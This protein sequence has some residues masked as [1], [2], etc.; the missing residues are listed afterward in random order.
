[1][2]HLDGHGVFASCVSASV[3]ADVLYVC[4]YVQVASLTGNGDVAAAVAALNAEMDRTGALHLH[5]ILSALG[6]MALSTT[7]AVEA[8]ELAAVALG[9]CAADT[10]LLPCLSPA[11]RL[12]FKMVGLG[13]LEDGAGKALEAVLGV[14]PALPSE[15]AADA[16]HLLVTLLSLD[17]SVLNIYLVTIASYPASLP[18]VEVL[19]QL[20]TLGCVSPEWLGLWCVKAAPG[21]G[22]ALAAALDHPRFIPVFVSLLEV[23]S[24][25]PAACE[26]VCSVMAACARAASCAT[27]PH[28]LTDTLLALVYSAA[29]QVGGEW[30]GV[31]VRVCVPVRCVNDLSTVSVIVCE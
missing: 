24:V 7:L 30:S 13:V 10:S 3:L 11:V 29:F 25:C 18:S 14:L 22:P 8:V 15:D 21:V 6:S 19:C 17:A 1:M 5:H 23:A 12:I 2:H 16:T 9:G 4:G 26:K 31:C 28:P 27:P 20:L